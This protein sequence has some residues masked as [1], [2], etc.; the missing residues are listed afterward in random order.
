M[1]FLSLVWCCIICAAGVNAQVI[2]VD[3][4]AHTRY[5][6]PLRVTLFKRLPVHT[7]YQLVNEKTG[8][9]T[10]AQLIDSNTLAFILPEKL[11]PQTSAQYT[12]QQVSPNTHKNAVTIEREP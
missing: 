8:V 7:Q 10:P 6:V 2:E 11:L 4:G 12:L 5:Q 1:R 9:S 3:A